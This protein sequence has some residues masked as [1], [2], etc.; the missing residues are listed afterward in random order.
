MKNEK[1]F[2]EFHAVFMVS[3]KI[4]FEVS[5]YRLGNNTN[6]DF[7]TS[8]F[9]FNQ[10]KSDYSQCGQAQE[11][12]KGVANKA[13]KFYKKWDKLHLSVMTRSQYCEMLEDM[14][15]LKAFYPCHIISDNEIRFSTIKDL[16][17]T[18]KNK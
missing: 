5:Y 16:S 17:M 12:L 4:G 3:R 9:E 7:T 2:K 10:P 13:Y 8:A 18:F 6:Q 14:E 11:I 15:S 1:D